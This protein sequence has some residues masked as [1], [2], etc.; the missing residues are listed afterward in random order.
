VRRPARVSVG[1][2]PASLSPLHVAVIACAVLSAGCWIVSVVTRNYSQVD[3]LWSIAPPLYVGWFA[4]SAG[5]GDA[6]LDLMAALALLWGARLTYNFAR[7]GGYR[8]GSE[9][10][11]WEAVRRR[12]GPVGFQILN[13]TFL[14]PLQNVLL[15]LLALPAARALE[16][17]GAPLGALDAAAA[18]GFLVF[19]AGEAVADEQQW[20]FQRDKRA[21]RARGEVAD[22]EFVTSGLFR[23]SRHPNFFC[24]MALWWS[25][26]LFSLAAGAGVADVAMLG[27]PLLTLLFQASTALTERLSLEKYPEYAAYQARTSRI[28]PL[29]RRQPRASR[30]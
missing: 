13:A 26:S 7:K 25:F 22:G 28:L 27:A 10:Y 5:L 29:P 17:R 14:A 9:D 20:R 16:R 15:L 21:R 18:A 2:M 30:S 6:R 23:W 11:R 19:L 12:V 1:A 8:A 4:A 3:R 24:E